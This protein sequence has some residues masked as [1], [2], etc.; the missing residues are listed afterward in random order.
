MRRSTHAILVTAVVLAVGAPG[1]TAKE[2]MDVSVCGSRCAS[3]A[4]LDARI[5]DSYAWVRA[6]SPAPFYTIRPTRPGVTP[7]LSGTLVY[8]PRKGIWRVRLEGVYVWLD[9]P[10]T[11]E[12][13]LRRAVRTLRPCPRS[14]SW[15]CARPA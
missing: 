2:S 12:P 5:T 4:G 8:L 15:A 13:I 7:G 14:R 10:F 11:N 9:V 3:V 1:A 6:P